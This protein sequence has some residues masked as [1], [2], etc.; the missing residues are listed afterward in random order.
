MNY[1][2]GEENINTHESLHCSVQ[3]L[4]QFLGLT[5]NKK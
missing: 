4:I 5:K 1:V 2:A 3:N